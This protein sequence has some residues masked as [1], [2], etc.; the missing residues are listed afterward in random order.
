MLSLQEFLKVFLCVFSLLILSRFL[1]YAFV[2]MIKA[3]RSTIDQEDP[4]DEPTE[5][6]ISEYTTTD[7][8]G[9]AA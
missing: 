2:M 3:K 6:F 4:D 8:R 5:E 7:V 1:V 9:K